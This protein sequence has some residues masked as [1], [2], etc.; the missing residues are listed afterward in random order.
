[1]AASLTSVQKRSAHSKH[2]YPAGLG[3]PT[4]RLKI[5]PNMHNVRCLNTYDALIGP[6]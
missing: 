6:T 3:E 2:P 1:M 4:V 5:G